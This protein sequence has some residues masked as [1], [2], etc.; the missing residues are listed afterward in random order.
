MVLSHFYIRIEKSLTTILLKF[1]VFA[2]TNCQ[3]KNMVG[4]DE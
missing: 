3:S 1:Y 2:D 4:K